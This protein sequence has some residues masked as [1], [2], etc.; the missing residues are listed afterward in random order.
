MGTIAKVKRGDTGRPLIIGC[1]YLATDIDLTDIIQLNTPVV[2]TMTKLGA[3]TP[4]IDKAAATITAID[5][6]TR[7]ITLTYQ[8]AAGQTDTAGRYNTEFEFTLTGGR[9]LTAPT[10]GYVLVIIEPD[11]A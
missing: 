6:A 11:L 10:D 4:T 3:T 8:W 5:T 7:T 1:H 2:F 9:P